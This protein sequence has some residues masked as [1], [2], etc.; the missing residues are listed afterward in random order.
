MP[1]PEF[2]MDTE[3]NY[4]TRFGRGIYNEKLMNAGKCHGY[5]FCSFWVIEGI[6]TWGK[7]RK[8]KGEEEIMIL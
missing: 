6:P 3:A 7:I 1:L 2:C 5:S 4:N 8:E